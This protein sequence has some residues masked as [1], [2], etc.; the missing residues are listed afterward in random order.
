MKRVAIL[1]L[2]LMGGSLALA[3]KRHRPDLR[4]S[5]YGRS[6]KARRDAIKRNAVDFIT[7]DPAA[8]VQHADLVVV[9]TPVL[10]IA[11][12]VAAAKP[13]LK[14]GCIVTDVGS[15]K[16]DVM[17]ALSRT[18]VGTK[19]HVIGSHPIAGSE[20][21]GMDAARTDLYEGALTIVCPATHAGNVAIT[22][23]E[24]FWASLNTRVL[25]MSATKHDAML[26][27][28]SHLPHLVAT[29]LVRA[30]L[31]GKEEDR[32]RFCGP[33]FRDSTRI[34]AGSEAMWSDIV[35]TNR[36]H[37]LAALKGFR[38]ECEELEKLIRSGADAALLDYLQKSRLDRQA[39]DLS[40]Q[41]GR[42]K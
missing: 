18:L 3:I 20:E 2:G 41:H 23:V 24:T 27:H 22:A 16:V 15:T 8:A 4:V 42:K 13:G 11:D 31:G 34:A 12:V 29:L 26:A 14:A 40:I 7:S 30:V 6:A 25:R 32:G 28:T 17:A 35:R 1:G 19:A 38:N 33:G 36:R 10:T 9:C 21:T 37:I 5:G 39:L